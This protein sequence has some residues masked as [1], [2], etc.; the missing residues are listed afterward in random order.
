M[1]PKSHL[2]NS[3]QLWVQVTTAN[4]LNMW[5]T[6]HIAYTVIWLQG[7][8]SFCGQKLSKQLILTYFSHL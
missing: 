6:K 7:I 4:G 8:Q 5:L 3:K 2:F 1:A